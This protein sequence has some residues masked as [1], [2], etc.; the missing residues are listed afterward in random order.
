LRPR[1]IISAIL[2]SIAAALHAQSGEPRSAP[3]T[4]AT[5]DSTLPD[6]PGVSAA[7]PTE[8]ILAAR[9]YAEET[10]DERPNCTIMRAAKVIHYTHDK[11][12]KVPPPCYELI[13]P[14]QRFL[15]T[16]V[17]IPLTWQQKGYL[18][19]HNFTDPFN[20][21]TI[22]GI[23]A[24]NVAADSHSAYGPGFKGWG[25]QMGVSYSQDATAGFFG[26]FLIPSLAHQDPRY[27]RM[28][29][30]HFA[31][32]L[33]HA[34]SQSYVAYHDDGHRMPNYSVI[35]TYPITAEISNLYVPGIQSDAR[36]TA[37]R[38]LVGYALDPVNN[39]VNEF[40]PD[41]AKRLHI[42]IIFVQNI[43]NNIAV[44]PSGPQP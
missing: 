31:R 5:S 40:L 17:V 4:Q 18:A 43:L 14:Y 12:G 41:V 15:T 3:S 33:V 13:D 36:S 32:R 6:A 7:N 27:Y 38:I 23:S 19:L 21:L 22:A 28:P 25:E 2:L 26:G 8:V 10:G 29:Q 11:P 39:I 35:F 37:D 24:I 30:A 16:Q 34:I 42:R 44:S 20:L 9:N 1:A